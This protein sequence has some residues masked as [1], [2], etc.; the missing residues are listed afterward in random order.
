MFHGA[1]INIF[2]LI[3]V[4]A[5]LKVL[6]AQS[7][8]VSTLSETEHGLIFHSHH[9]SLLTVKLEEAAMEE[10]LEV[11]IPL[12]RLMVFLKKVAKTIL[13]KIL[14]TSLALPF[15]NV[16]IALILRLKNPEIKETV[17]LPQNIQSGKLPNTVLSQE[18]TT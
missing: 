4:H 13:L 17:G 15:K 7:L 8:I 2:Q 14:I 6:P 11:S 16:W 12:L 1:K 3:V 9:K 18:L 10:T 5:G